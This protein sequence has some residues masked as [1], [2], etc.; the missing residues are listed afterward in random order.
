MSKLET[1]KL[2]LNELNQRKYLLIACPSQERLEQAKS[3]LKIIMKEMEKKKEL[4]KLAMKIIYPKT[5][6]KRK[7]NKDIKRYIHK[8]N[9]SYSCLKKNCKQINVRI[10][11]VHIS[12]KKRKKLGIKKPLKFKK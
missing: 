12:F 5:A 6:V 9:K 1:I 10:Y 4:I 11:S 3:E 7:K 2:E 8:R